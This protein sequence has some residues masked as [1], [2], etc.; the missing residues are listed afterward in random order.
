MF[1]PVA[2]K[3]EDCCVFVIVGEGR[4]CIVLVFHNPLSLYFCFILRT[5]HCVQDNTCSLDDCMLQIRRIKD[6][7]QAD[8]RKY[9][10]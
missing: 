10:Q 5:T 2:L 9:L 3:A 6:F 7:A 1:S 4:D 8:F